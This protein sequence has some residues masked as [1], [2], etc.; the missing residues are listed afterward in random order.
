MESDKLEGLR[1]FEILEEGRVRERI[2][3]N[4]MCLEVIEVA[5]VGVEAAAHVFQLMPVWQLRA[6]ALSFQLVHGF[7]EPFNGSRARVY[8]EGKDHDAQELDAAVGPKYLGLLH[9]QRESQPLAQELFYL[10]FQTQEFL[11]VPADDVEVVHVSAVK[12]AAQDAF[13]E[14]IKLVHVHVGEELRGDVADGESHAGRSVLQELLRRDVQEL[15]FRA[16]GNTPF[17]W[18]SQDDYRGQVFDQVQ[19]QDVPEAEAKRITGIHPFVNPA[20]YQIE[21]D[22]PVDGHEVSAQ[23]SFEDIALVLVVLR[24]GA[25]VVCKAFPPHLCPFPFLA[26]IAVIDE[27]GLQDGSEVVVKKS[28]YHPVR[29]TGA[30][31]FPFYRVF[32]QESFGWSRVVSAFVDGGAGRVEVELQVHFILYM[33]IRVD[34]GFPGILVSG[35]QVVVQ[36][37]PAYFHA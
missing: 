31:D 10:Y 26:G 16:D 28:A 32:A 12:L 5:E 37:F 27:R 8:A 20:Q 23:V 14:A 29:E 15:C 33:G 11:L 22:L 4:S 13:D 18:V 36:C 7:M 9:V 1:Q 2:H 3:D 6:E 34:L 17:Q 25:D 21:Q 35:M 30:E 24:A 19:I